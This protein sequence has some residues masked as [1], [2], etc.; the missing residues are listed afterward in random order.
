MYTT[1]NGKMLSGT[2]KL[3][4]TPRTK[5]SLLVT[6]RHGVVS[7]MR[8]TFSSYIFAANILVLITFILS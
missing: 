3:F 6:E 2:K 1:L 4:T 5:Y 8:K 7:S